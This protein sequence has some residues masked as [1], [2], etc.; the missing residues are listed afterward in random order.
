MTKIYNKRRGFLV[1]F[2]QNTK[3][4]IALYYSSRPP[5]VAEMIAVGKEFFPRLQ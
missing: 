4:W 2:R 1:V 5:D 3:K